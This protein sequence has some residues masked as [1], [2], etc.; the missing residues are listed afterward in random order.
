MKLRAAEVSRPLA[1]VKRI[2]E[3]R[4]TVVFDDS[5]SFILN[6]ATGE[7][8]AL[9]EE[10]GNCVL[11]LWV[12]PT[13]E[14]G[15]APCTQLVLSRR[16]RKQGRQTMEKHTR[17]RMSWSRSVEDVTRNPC[18]SGKKP[19]RPHRQRGRG[20]QRH[21]PP[22]P[23]VVFGVREG[24]RKRGSAQESARTRRSPVIR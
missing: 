17:S 13:N 19:W 10:C 4:H 20:A 1:S 7:I 16:I 3:A 6:K 18:A 21:A 12:P 22:A 5:G 11:D 9:R 15:L 2:C 23:L 8:N 14:L 24:Q